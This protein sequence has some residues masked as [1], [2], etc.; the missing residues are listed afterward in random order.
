MLFSLIVLISFIG[1]S[2]GFVSNLP[3]DFGSGRYFVAQ[4]LS[5]TSI[6]RTRP[7]A[8]F[9]TISAP[10]KVSSILLDGVGRTESLP[11]SHSIHPARELTYM[12]MFRDQL[13][14][15]SELNMRKIPID[16]R[17]VDRQSSVKPARIGS[18]CFQNEK[19]RKVRMTY[20]DAGD[21]VQVT[22]RNVSTTASHLSF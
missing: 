5:H 13:G 6:V 8:R 14:K 2:Y 4:E 10:P 15:L 12:P 11:W 21:A 17:F 22:C 16:E 7:V 3:G 1:L 9:A 18:M 19:F 20:F